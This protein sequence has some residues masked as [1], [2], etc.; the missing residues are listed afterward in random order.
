MNLNE[1][2][3]SDHKS[4]SFTVSVNSESHPQG[5]TRRRRFIDD[6][7]ILKFSSLFNFKPSSDEVDILINSFNEHCLAILNQ[8]APFKTSHCT[9][10]SCTPWLN[11]QTRGL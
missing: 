2:V 6:S 3:F 11:N 5:S 7:V 4:V 10:S 8:V 9:V 1:V